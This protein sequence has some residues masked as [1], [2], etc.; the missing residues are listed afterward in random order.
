MTVSPRAWLATFVALVL[1]IGVSAGV[2]ID[3]VWLVRPRPP[4]ALLIGGPLGPGGP[5]GPAPPQLVDQLDRR[6]HL[7]PEQRRQILSILETHRPRVR[8]L[9]TDA[10]DRFVA[11]Q[12]ALMAEINA[13]LTPEQATRLRE[14]LMRRRPLQPGRGRG[15]PPGRE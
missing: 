10:R 8:Q 3:R 13:V 12:D 9:L 5:G 7:T 15:G 4:G 6:L 1:L 11:E 14:L 2:L